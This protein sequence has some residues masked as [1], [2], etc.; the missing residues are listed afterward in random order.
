MQG[1]S[2]MA[3][4]LPIQEEVH[5]YHCFYAPMRSSRK[6]GFQCINCC[7]TVLWFFKGSNCRCVLWAKRSNHKLGIQSSVVRL[8]EGATVCEPLYHFLFYQ[9]MGGRVS[10]VRGKS[11]GLTYHDLI[12]QYPV[13][14]TVILSNVVTSKGVI[15]L[16]EFGDAQLVGDNRKVCIMI[17]FIFFQKGYNFNPKVLQPLVPYHVRRSRWENHFGVVFK[18]NSSY[19]ETH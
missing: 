5:L 1:Y 17:P 9:Y 19:F 18:C 7:T 2:R 8:V 6:L 3:V 4:P 12:P 15:C 14:R 11:G 10:L 13:D 16:K